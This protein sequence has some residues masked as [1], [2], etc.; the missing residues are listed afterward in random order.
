MAPPVHAHR[1]LNGRQTALSRVQVGAASPS[2]LIP[3]D[4]YQTGRKAPD[5]WEIGGLSW[6]EAEAA[7]LTL[8]VGQDWY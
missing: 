3:S 5:S 2:N 6:G 8:Y 1:A 4:E 7:E